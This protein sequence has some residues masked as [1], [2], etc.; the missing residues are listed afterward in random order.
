MPTDV[1]SDKLMVQAA[2]LLVECR[3]ER[4]SARQEASDLRTALLDAQL[5]EMG[6][7]AAL[8][9]LTEACESDFMPE[10]AGPDDDDGFW[11][12]DESV[13]ESTEEKSAV[14][15]GMIRRARA[16]IAQ[17]EAR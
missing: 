9:D 15:F 5:R 3:R 2:T 8:R 11:G 17:A 7:L 1:I 4:D 16:A 10:H 6:L 13:S 12:D 14:T